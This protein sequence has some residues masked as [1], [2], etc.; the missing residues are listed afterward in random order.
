MKILTHLPVL[1]TFALVTAVLHAQA[2]PAEGPSAKPLQIEVE[3]QGIPMLLI[4]GLASSADVWDE[5]VARYRDR[6]ECHSI[7]LAGFAGQPPIVERPYLST[8]IEAIRAYIDEKQLEKPILVGHSL[9]GFLALSLASKFPQLVGPLVI[10]DGFP[11]L[12]AT[13]MGP[14]VTPELMVPQAEQM[15]AY[16]ASQT[17]EQYEASVR[18]GKILRTMISQEED[19]DRAIQWGLASDKE[20]VGQVMYEL[21][22]TDL[23]DNLHRIQSPT[24]VMTTWIAYK[25]YTSRTLAESR[26]R[27]QYEGL[28]G[29][30]LVMF[31]DARHFVMYDNPDKYYLVLDE[32]LAGVE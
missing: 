1:G 18:S 25:E 22:T 15:R 8:M 21:L 20:T 27:D 29:V 13:W 4:P 6:Y 30:S 24:L 23:R 17:Q 16:Y 5:T 3:G 11:F 12:P 10:V 7:T 32:F 31:D 9:G 19:I 14:D 28:D 26:Y 2:R